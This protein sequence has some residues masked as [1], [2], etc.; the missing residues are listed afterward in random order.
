MSNQVQ[1]SNRHMSLMAVQ[2]LDRITIYLYHL[3][4]FPNYILFIVPFIN[5]HQAVDYVEDQSIKIS[6]IDYEDFLYYLHECITIMKNVQLQKPAKNL[7]HKTELSGVELNLTYVLA[8]DEFLL[9]MSSKDCKF[10]FD[11]KIIPNLLSAI[12]SII[13]KSFCYSHQ[14][15]YVI[16]TFVKEAPF[17][18]IKNPTCNACFTILEKIDVVQVDYFLLFDIIQRH[19]KILL[20]LKRF[21]EF[22]DE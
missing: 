14:I 10:T 11:T 12:A 21:Q 5:V 8:T 19:K 16:S 4:C 1:L 6:H 7:E 22:H 9:S 2:P 3:L 13:F 18:L 17:N 20:Y 15:N